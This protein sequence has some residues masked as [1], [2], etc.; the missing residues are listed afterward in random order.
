[1]NDIVRS[2]LTLD[3]FDPDFEYDYDSLK[4]PTSDA[5]LGRSVVCLVA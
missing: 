2:F 4:K 3:V 5:E 1:M